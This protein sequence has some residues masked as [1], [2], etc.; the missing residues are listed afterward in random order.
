MVR[1]SSECTVYDLIGSRP[2][3]IVI[4]IITGLARYLLK[5]HL[6]DIRSL[7]VNKFINTFSEP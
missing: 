7:K 5:K 4:G 3:E 2:M 1:L 6:Y